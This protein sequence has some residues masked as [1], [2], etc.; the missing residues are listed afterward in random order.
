MSTELII[1][2]ELI[3]VLVIVLLVSVVVWRDKTSEASEL[4]EVNQALMSQ[5]EQMQG[6]LDGK[7]ETHE[8][9]AESFQDLDDELD[10][11]VTT[12]LDNANANLGDMEKLVIEHRGILTE[13]DG[14]LSQSDPDVGS[15]RLEI[16]KLK[17]LLATTEKGILEYKARLNK[18]ETSVKSLK[19]NMRELSKQIL[20]M[21]SLEVSEGR[22]KRDKTRLMDR[23]SKLEDKYE[24][25]K[26][27]AK[28]LENELK[29]SFK[30]GEVQAMKDDLRNTEEQL[31]RTMIE[32]AFIEQHFLELANNADPEELDRELKRVK[33]EMRQLEKG[34]LDSD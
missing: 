30:A 26:V 33:R 28:N 14:F 1:I 24:N 25:E 4:R 20:T 5:L 31:K 3:A 16:D 10:E 15:A 9:V 27:L 32:K 34:I 2:L 17:A 21:N 23:M 18:S 12:T 19:G 6:V 11:Q 13:L 29:T 8:K 7:N 22:L